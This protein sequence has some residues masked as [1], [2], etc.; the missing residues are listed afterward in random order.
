MKLKDVLTI[1]P[2][3][4]HMVY[5]KNRRHIGRG[6]LDCIEAEVLSLIPVVEK[7]ATGKTRA[8]LEIILD[9]DYDI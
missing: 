7:S 9:F 8:V 4:N 3:D 5:S 1:I 2:A 6:K